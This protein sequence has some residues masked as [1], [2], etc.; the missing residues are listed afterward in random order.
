VAAV[1]VR[2]AL[3]WLGRIIGIH[4]LRRTKE[5]CTGIEM[6]FDIV[7]KVNA[8]AQVRAGGQPNR[9][10]AFCRSGLDGAINGR[11]VQVNSIARGA[12]RPDVE[13]SWNAGVG[14]MR[15]GVT[16]RSD[17]SEQGDEHHKLRTAGLVSRREL[18]HGEN[19]NH[20]P[21]AGNLSCAALAP[22]IRNMAIIRS[23]YAMKVGR[24]VPT[25]PQVVQT[26]DGGLGTARP[27]NLPAIAPPSSDHSCLA[28]IQE[29]P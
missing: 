3:P 15:H 20:P 18:C 10:T 14:S 6:Q 24:G 2:H 28:S 4:L 8:A 5:G 27:T 9:A 13:D 19:C 23:R 25:A 21:K 1:L 17:Q 26:P 22:I 12:E 16:I 29:I 11:T 7:R